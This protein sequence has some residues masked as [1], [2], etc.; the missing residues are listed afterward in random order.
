MNRTRT[1]N[2]INNIFVLI[3]FI[4]AG[5]ASVFV[6]SVDTFENI[7]G[8]LFIIISSLL[9]SS[10]HKVGLKN[11]FLYLIV[12]YSIYFILLTVK[13]NAFHP[14]FY[15]IYFIG[16]YLSYVLISTLKNNYFLIFENVLVKLCMVSI[17]FW[18]LLM[19][20]PSF[21]YNLFESISFL[22]PGTKLVHSNIIFFTLNLNDSEQILKLENILVYRNAGFSWEP[23]GFAVLINLGMFV[24]LIR[25]RFR[26]KNNK[27]IR[28]FLLALI[29]TFSTT[30]YGIFMVLALLFIYNNKSKYKALFVTILIPLGIYLLSLPFM[31]DKLIKVSD[32][33]IDSE[34]ESSILYGGHKTPQRINSFIIDYQDFTNNPILGYG[35]HIDERWT[36]KLGADIASISGIGKVFAVFGLVGVIFFFT[37]LYKSS[38]LFSLN[39]NFKG[40][41]FPFLMILMISISYSLIFNP[42]LMCF[43]MYALF[44]P[45]F[46]TINYSSLSNHELVK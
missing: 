45:K 15:F 46:K 19:L 23:G 29:T 35:G 18:V 10:Y 24:N 44:M 13:F 34:V 39:Y 36:R 16:F 31:L 37:L 14:R 26:I 28:I 42:L 41:I 25:Y 3:L 7:Y 40:W 30:G 21:L 1:T 38:K 5:R 12:G 8:L 9:F 27:N 2:F 17:V 6:R 4:Y 11:S 20:F 43:W 32:N 22:T 33:N